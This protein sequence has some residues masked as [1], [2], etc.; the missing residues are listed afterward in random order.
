[1]RIVS[2]PQ[3][4]DAEFEA[5]WASVAATWKPVTVMARECTYLVESVAYQ[6]I[7]PGSGV[8]EVFPYA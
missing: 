4:S 7:A 5:L 1:M 2:P 3:V 8:V 6:H